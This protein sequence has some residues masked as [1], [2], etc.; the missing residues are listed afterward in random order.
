MNTLK[1]IPFFLFLYLCPIYTQGQEEPQA[2]SA[3]FW[4]AE[5]MLGK[6]VPTYTDFPKTDP[7][8][9]IG[10][11]IGR[12]RYDP[13]K[14]W[15]RFFRTPQTGV[16]A[17]FTQLGN[18][19]EL[20]YSF[21]VLPYL[22][23][24]PF[25]D[26]KQKWRFRMGLG[27][28]YYTKQFDQD[29]NPNNKS[30]GSAVAWAFQLFLY[31][32]LYTGP[33]SNWQIGFGTFQSSNGHARLPSFGM[34]TVSVSL[35]AQ[36]FQ[37]PQPS[38]TSAQP[39]TEQSS[40]K[41]ALIIRTGYGFHELGGTDG[42]LDGP[43]KGVYSLALHY[44]WYLRPFIR[45]RTGI[46]YRYFQ[47]Y[48]DYIVD[49]NLPDFIDAPELNA[50]NLFVSAGIEFLLDHVGLDIEMG[51][52][53]Y[54]PFFDEFYDTFEMGSSLDR[55]LSKILVS[56]LGLHLYLLNTSRH[57]KNNLFLGAHISTN[58][59]QDFTSFSLGYVRNL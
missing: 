28:S 46:T 23:F 13:E 36:F 22:S 11:S 19:R 37:P 29:I 40:Y 31:H 17:I 32:K 44:A 10:L 47:A 16:T 35:L 25:K 18:N 59:G 58:Y 9:S 12:E 27:A 14:A 38:I 33:R 39:V 8:S 41:N 15:T 21:N 57:P 20:G 5:V 54:Q 48:H 7:A 34:N 24:S 45:L 6:V 49:H 51:L 55:T 53:L 52:N 56:R 50:S 42:R 2:S 4:T 1:L 30:T 26:P 3:F 43:Q